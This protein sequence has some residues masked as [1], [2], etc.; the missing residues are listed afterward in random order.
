MRI[1][2]L[3]T[4]VGTVPLCDCE[5]QVCS[6]ESVHCVKIDVCLFLKN[7][8]FFCLDAPNEH[9]IAQKVYIVGEVDQQEERKYVMGCQVKDEHPD[10]LQI[11]RFSAKTLVSY[12][13]N[14]SRQ[15]Q[16]N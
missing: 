12:D 11:Q 14:V 10:Q 13:K 3:F 1:E 4:A 5:K 7:G 6:V 15:Q 16:L 2:P 8:A 9:I